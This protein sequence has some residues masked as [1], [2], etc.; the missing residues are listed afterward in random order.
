MLQR[1]RVPV[2]IMEAVKNMDNMDTTV[3]N[4]GIAVKEDVVHKPTWIGAEDVVVESTVILHITVGHIE[5]VPIQANTAGPRQTDTRRTRCGAT[6]YWQVSL[7]AP[8]RLVRYLLVK[9][10]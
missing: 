7:T 10:M 2:K 3:T 9:L 1:L 4:P 5:C 6:G 8:A